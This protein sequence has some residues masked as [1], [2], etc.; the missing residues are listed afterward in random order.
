MSSQ[1]TTKHPVADARTM[2]S[3]AHRQR[4]MYLQALRD[5]QITIVDVI[6]A[7]AAPAGTYLRKIR[8]HHLLSA[9][10]WSTTK[11]RHAIN[12][13]TTITG[14]DPNTTPTISWLID[15]R[16]GGRR[17]VAWANIVNADTTPWTGFPY[18]PPPPPVT[19][20]NHE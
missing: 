5:E 10:G 9:A 19:G 4:Y 14:T 12:L 20:G 1:N 6:R 16:A 7:A 15:P 13:L 8:L 18:A 17:I 3:H 2:I 11:T